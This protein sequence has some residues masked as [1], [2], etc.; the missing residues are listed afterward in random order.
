[1]LA[2]DSPIEFVVKSGF[3]LNPKPETLNPNMK[4]LHGVPQTSLDSDKGL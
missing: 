1:M 4:H 3:A 2:S